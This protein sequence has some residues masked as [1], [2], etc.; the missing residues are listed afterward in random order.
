MKDG[1]TALYRYY[2]DEDRL[3][4]IGISGALADRERTHIGSSRWMDLSARSEIVRYPSRP[5]AEEAEREAIETEQPL[6]NK[7]HNN[8]PE[9]KRWLAAYLREIGRSDWLEEPTAPPRLEVVPA[10][11]GPVVRL[12]STSETFQ[13]IER[14]VGLTSE[15]IDASRHLVEVHAET[16][17]RLK[18]AEQR[19]AVLE[20]ATSD[21]A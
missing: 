7:Q 1:P 8:T 19:L 20:A 12:G 5:E 13:V 10:S 3:L 2:D 21:A 18:E 14:L 16:I 15:M 4:Y 9:A 17:A 11:V 6:F